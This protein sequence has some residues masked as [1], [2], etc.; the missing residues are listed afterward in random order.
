M[1]VGEEDGSSL[2]YLQDTIR[3]EF[4]VFTCGIDADWTEKMQRITDFNTVESF[5]STMF[6][7]LP[8][9]DIANG[10]DLYIFKKGIKPMWEDPMNE[11]GGRWLINIPPDFIDDVNFYWEELL[12]L[13]VGSYWETEEDSKEICGVVFQPRARGSKIS[14]WTSNWKNKDALMRIGKRVKEVLKY[15]ETLLYQ[16]VDQQKHVPK[17]QDMDISTYKV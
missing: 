1:A 5:W 13:I 8:P 17:G 12:M 4:F 2:H 3:W 7:T 15:P 11:N 14:L 6:H 10:T 16:T 9:A